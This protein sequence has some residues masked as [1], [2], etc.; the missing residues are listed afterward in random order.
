[1]YIM[2][3]IIKNEKKLNKLISILIEL[4]LYDSTILD[5]ECIETGVVDTLPLFKE[6]ALLFSNEEFIYNKTII[7]QVPDK[8]T[9]D[10]FVNICLEE[11]IDF[12]KPNI[13]SVMA[14]KCDLF[15]GE[16]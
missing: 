7:T 2:I 3:V 16:L 15:V 13:G 12:T 9:L 10:A 4:G 1:M 14:F 6:L 8:E 5:G 11:D